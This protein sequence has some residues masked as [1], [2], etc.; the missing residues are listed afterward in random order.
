M[1]YWRHSST[2]TDGEKEGVEKKLAGRR[3]EER[4]RDLKAMA[5]IL[6]ISVIIPWV[7]YELQGVV[8]WIIFP[9]ATLG[10]LAI[11]YTVHLF[12]DR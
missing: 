4:R 8:P 5:L 12:Y 3:G 1:E 9:A 6:L 11:A 10:L 7:I 2:T